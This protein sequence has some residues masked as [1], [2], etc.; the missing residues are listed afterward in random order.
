MYCTTIH[1]HT[2]HCTLYFISLK[3]LKAHLTN[4]ERETEINYLR[5]QLTRLENETLVHVHVVVQYGIFLSLS[6]SV[7]QRDQ[8][9]RL[10]SDLA[11]KQEELS[12]LTSEQS[13]LSLQK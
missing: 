13:T 9:K 8:I 11:I 6:P 12:R 10:R 7:A 4:E 2:I 5:Q 3:E 1:T